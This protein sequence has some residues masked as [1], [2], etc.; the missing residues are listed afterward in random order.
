ME[1]VIGVE[2]G[3]VQRRVLRSLG[4][5]EHPAIPGVEHQ[6]LDLRH[7]GLVLRGALLHLSP[8]RGRHA[9]RLS[10]RTARTGREFLVVGLDRGARSAP[11][12][13]HRLVE[14]LQRG[15]A[16]CE[17]PSDRRIR[18]QRERRR[19]PGALPH[20][21]RDLCRASNRVAAHWRVLSICP[22]PAP[23]TSKI[24]PLKWT[25]TSS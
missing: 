9:G 3:V 17:A 20:R 5:D 6:C 8:Q 14:L 4:L 7:D 2:P 18:Q 13:I 25:C 21:L 16:R 11:P 15:L 19:H 1:S 23:V 22:P 24:R 10:D 12:G